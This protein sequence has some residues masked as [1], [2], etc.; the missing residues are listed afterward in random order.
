MDTHV[1][2]LGILHIAFGL[3]GMVGALVLLLFFGGAAALVGGS[4]AEGA[5]TAVPILGVVG[6]LLGCFVLVVS[7]PGLIAGIGVLTFREWARILMLVVSALDLLNVPFGTALGVYG[8]WTLL[9][10]ETIPLFRKPPL[11]TPG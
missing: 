5:R 4:G 10:A 9:H 6:A 1:R 7:L 3:M 11:R 2:V 8:F